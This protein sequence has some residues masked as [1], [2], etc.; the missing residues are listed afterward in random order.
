MLQ[1]LT[2]KYELFKLCRLYELC[3]LYEYFVNH[4]ALPEI[5]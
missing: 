3:K 1:K 2:L 4:L 5:I